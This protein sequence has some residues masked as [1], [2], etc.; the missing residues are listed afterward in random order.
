[1]I[2]I[3]F[4]LVAYRYL[5]KKDYVVHFEVDCDP[6]GEPC[7][8]RNCDPLGRQKDRLCTGDPDK[9]IRYYK[10]IHKNSNKIS[11][12]DVN[13]EE[14]EPLFC[15]ENEPDCGF[16]FC[17]KDNKEKYGADFC[18]DPMMYRVANP[19][20]EKESCQNGENCQDDSLENMQK[21]M[22]QST[23]DEILSEN[24]GLNKEDLNN[25]ENLPVFE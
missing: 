20:D 13:E 19:K 5:I 10:I 23:R 15:G 7:F 24:E 9:D 25:K 18:N 11:S 8:V 21:Q 22:E 4:G 6:Y 1:M 14:C 2:F 17:N 12:C 16:V 3:S